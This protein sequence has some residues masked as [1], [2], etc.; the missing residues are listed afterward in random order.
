MRKH[1]QL[2]GILNIIWGS[3]SVLGALIILLIFG[4]ATWLIAALSH[5]P[6]AR[7]AL[8]IVGLFG[9]ALALLLLILS[10][11][12]IITGIGLL[13]LAPWGRVLGIVVSALHLF[14]VPFGTALGAYGLW[15]LLSNDTLPLFGHPQ[16]PI[17]TQ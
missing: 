4:G 14:S 16:G 7:I 12:S 6:D 11:P 2:L 9:G 8:P 3:L 10:I 13:R 5:E 1:I 15:V 17:G